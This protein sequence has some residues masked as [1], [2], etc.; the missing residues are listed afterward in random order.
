MEFKGMKVNFLGDSITEGVG[1]SS[2]EKRF[3]DVF[4]RKTGA[5]VRNYGISGSRI[6]R[7]KRNELHQDRQSYVERYD[8]MDKDADLIVVFGGTND[9]GHGDSTFGQFDDTDEYTFCGAMNSLLSGLIAAY[10]AARIVI[11]TPMHRLSENVTVNEIGL[12]CRPLAE[13]V[14]MEKRIAEK[15]SVPVLDLWG[16]SGMQPCIPA[17]KELYVPDG[18]HPNDRGAERIADMLIRFVRDL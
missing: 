6:A 15:Y 5:L 10:P 3:P 17:Q 9:F 18:L 1:V 14:A 7:Q 2:I 4:G 16:C 11:M 13:Y 12:P 8:Q